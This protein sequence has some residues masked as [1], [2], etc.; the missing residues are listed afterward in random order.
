VQSFQAAVLKEPLFITLAALSLLLVF[1]LWAFLRKTVML[2]AGIPPNNAMFRI[3]I[4]FDPDTARRI[5]NLISLLEGTQQKEIDT[6][7]AKLKAANDSL[8]AQTAS[9]S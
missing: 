9:N 6:L 5:D 2:R 1:C 8:A 3:F 4:S 7:T